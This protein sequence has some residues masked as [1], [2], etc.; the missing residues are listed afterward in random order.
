MSSLFSDKM[1]IGDNMKNR[2]IK[3][4]F[5]MLAFFGIGIGLW[6]TFQ[7]LW[8]EEMGILPQEISRIFSLSSLFSCVS[9]LLIGFK[10]DM[11]QLKNFMLSCLGINICALSLLYFTRSFI[12]LKACAILMIVSQ[13]TYLLFFLSIYPF[14]T[15]ITKDNR[16]YGKRKLVQYVFEDLGILFGGILL[17]NS[18]GSMHFDYQFFLGVTILMYLIAFVILLSIPTVKKK[19]ISSVTLRSYFHYLKKNRLQKQYYTYI[20]IGNISYYTVFGMQMLLLTNSLVLTAKGATLFCLVA[21]VLADILGVVALA[22]LTPK[23]TYITLFIK[24]GIRMTLYLFV[25]LVPSKFFALCALFWSLLIGHAYEDKTDGVYINQN[26]VKYQL[27]AANFRN[28]VSYLGKS[29][30]IGLCGIFFGL[31]YPFMFL[32]ASLIGYIQL[33]LAWKTYAVYKKRSLFS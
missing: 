31:G 9:I 26:P 4:I 15:T 22:K 30:G 12:S 21:S 32:V 28:L 14:I 2:N 19:D 5:T 3:S 27:A 8:L 1:I 18:L 13:V 10:I 6:S 11:R 33:F 25:F 20:L 23:N 29:I 16:I 17:G 24:F 7:Q